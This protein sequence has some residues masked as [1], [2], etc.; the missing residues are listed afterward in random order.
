MWAPT[1]D[2]PAGRLD[3]FR[4]VFQPGPGLCQFAV[5]FGE[6][7]VADAAVGLCP[8]MQRNQL[9]VILD[10][11]GEQFVVETACRQAGDIALGPAAVLA[12]VFV[13]LL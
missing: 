9:T 4:R 11:L 10:R 12:K 5:I 8:L 2:R 1:D 13:G 7:P 6:R 3:R